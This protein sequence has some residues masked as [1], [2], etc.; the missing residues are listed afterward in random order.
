MAKINTKYW[1]GQV[2]LVSWLLI[3]LAVPANAIS[4]SGIGIFPALTKEYTGQQRSW[5]VYEADLGEEI[6]DQVELR[7]D[8]DKP[9]VVNAAVL[10]GAVTDD[11][12]YTLVDKVEDNKDIGTWATLSANKVTLAAHQRKLIDLTIKVP[13]TADVGSHAGGVVIWEDKASA[14]ST[15]KSAG[16]LSVVTRV[17]ARLYLTVPGD[18]VRRLDISNV[19]HT[20]EKGVLYFNMSLHNGG[21]V[22]LLPVADITLRGIF[23]QIGEQKNSSFGMLLRETSIDSRTPWQKKAP[24]F[25]RFVADFR[26]HYG[27]KDFKG[28]YVKD[29]YQDV[30]YVFWLVPWMLLLWIILGILLLWFVRKLWIWILIR[31]RLGTKTIEH[32]VKKGE[33]LTSIADIY[34]VSPKTIAKFNLL[35]W[36]YDLLAG[37][38]LLI[39]QRKLTKEEQK[40]LIHH[41]RAVSM[42]SSGLPRGSRPGFRLG[43]RNDNTPPVFASSRKLRL[44][45]PI[46]PLVRG[47]VG[48][49]NLEPVITEAGD[50]VKTVAQFAGVGAKVIIQLNRLK[51]PYHLRAGQE[52]LIPLKQTTSQLVSSPRRTSSPGPKKT[53]R[54]SPRRPSKK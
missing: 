35:K 6:K 8:T 28:E 40:E 11:G 34:E 16:Q 15:G 20:I 7:N 29:E 9:M 44:A 23:S 18:I 51:W 17:A 10:D 39:P 50:T 19:H 53:P 12:A 21:N 47:G 43:G 38:V 48:G 3:N 49:V 30:R 37:D 25:G 45:S 32:P 5:F 27:E 24:V 4:A 33:T 36:P 41:P 54:R 31:K 13:L 14:G 1:L 22:T 2:F 42:S 46:L 52:L 26:I